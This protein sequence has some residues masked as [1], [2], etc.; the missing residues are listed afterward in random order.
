MCREN[1]RVIIAEVT[2]HNAPANNVDGYHILCP[3]DALAIRRDKIL[4][5]FL[6]KLWGYDSWKCIDTSAIGY[7]FP[8]KSH[9]IMTI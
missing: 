8:L 5:S 9:F 3:C 1:I 4:R 2:G 7:Y 6:A